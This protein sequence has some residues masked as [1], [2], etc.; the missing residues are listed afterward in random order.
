MNL[1]DIYQS[2]LENDTT[3]YF[4]IDSGQHFNDEDFIQYSWNRT[5]NNKIKEN[6]LFIY[7][8]PQ[9]VSVNSKFYLYG[10]G[11][12]GSIS[13]S[14]EV[15]SKVVLPQQF[16]PPI[17]QDELNDF[18][19]EMKTRGANWEHFW[20]QYGINELTKRD[21][22]RLLAT[23][24]GEFTVQAGE[25]EAKTNIEIAEGN[26]FVPDSLA[27]SKSRPWQAAWSK[28][29]KENYGF[30]CAICKMTTPAMLVGSHIVPVRDD[31]YNRKNPANGICLCVLHDSAFDKGYLTLSDEL[32]VIITPTLDDPVLAHIL[33]PVSG[34]K[35]QAPKRYSPQLEF[36]EH[37][38]SNIFIS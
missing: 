31:Q 37:H 22:V 7:R 4:I 33:Q 26:Y 17:F 9:K 34:R 15:T 1:I 35:I 3:A 10:T 27:M 2:E 20:N 5:I 6:D 23:Q 14:E 28:K 19:W 16:D 11:K 24:R 36:L 12:F 38:R 30:Q 8:N 21:F 13:G 18:N 25:E 32:E 29:V